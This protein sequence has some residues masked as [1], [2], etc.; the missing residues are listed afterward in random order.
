MVTSKQR[1]ALAQQFREWLEITQE[2]TESL[3]AS[4]IKEAG[5]SIDATD[6]EV[7]ERIYRYLSRPANYR[8]LNSR[9]IDL[10][11]ALVGGRA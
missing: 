9:Q 6:P 2:L 11:R 7:M 8:T 4:N 1:K 10:V 3:E 5:V